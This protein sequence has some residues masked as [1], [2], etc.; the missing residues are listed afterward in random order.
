MRANDR[1]D[2]IQMDFR[3]VTESYQFSIFVSHS[4]IAIFD[5]F[6]DRPLNEWTRQHVDQGFSWR[7]GSVSFCTL[8]E[9]GEHCV[10]LFANSHDSL[11]PSDAVRV[12]EVPFEVPSSGAVELGSIA[13]SRP[14]HIPAGLYQLRFECYPRANSSASRIRFLLD[15]N[16][17]PKFRIVRA[18]SAL[19]PGTELL[20]TASPA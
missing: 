3:A 5:R 8:E 14:L 19:R 1:P 16:P 2:H 6:L 17:E 4:Q 13:D 20:L 9:A 15:E 18:D 11:A 10:A 7:A 12:I